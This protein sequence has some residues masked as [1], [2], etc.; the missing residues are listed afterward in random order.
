MRTRSLC[1]VDGFLF[2]A[3]VAVVGAVA[4]PPLE[5]AR[6]AQG[7]QACISNE[8]QLAMAFQQYAKDYDGR[9]P[10]GIDEGDAANLHASWVANLFPYVKS[11]SLFACPDDTTKPGAESFVDS[12]AANLNLGSQ[13][14]QPDKGSTSLAAV[15]APSKVVLLCE[16]DGEMWSHTG[17]AAGGNV[18]C[19]ATNGTISR[20]GI[21]LGNGYGLGAGTSTPG[22]WLDTGVFPNSGG[23]PGSLPFRATARHQAGSNYAFVD[24]HAAWLKAANVSAGISNRSGISTDCG[25][26]G[27]SANPYNEAA[28]TGAATCPYGAVTATFS[29]K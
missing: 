6:T 24:G 25:E 8:R 3:V 17:Y 11:E 1:W 13:P 20:W 10:Q 19:A 26:T 18:N 14:K 2:G 22:I 21:V 4:L 12:Y 5:Y 9:L 29:L 15:V 16:V 7:R 27:T 23:T 28:A